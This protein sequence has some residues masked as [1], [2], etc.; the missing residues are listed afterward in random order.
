VYTFSS[1]EPVK[2]S[3]YNYQC[4]LFTRLCIRYVHV[5]GN[6]EQEQQPL[7]VRR[8]LG[9]GPSSP[10]SLD[11]IR[12]IFKHRALTLQKEFYVSY[13]KTNE[14][15]LFRDILCGI[16]NFWDRCCHPYSSCSSVMQRLDVLI[17]CVVLFGVVYLAWCDVA[18]DPTAS[19]QNWQKLQRRPWQWLDKHSGKKAWAAHGESELADTQ[20]D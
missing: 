12:T 2:I 16:H 18:I 1:V 20:K 11:L 9:S 4:S 19:V 14:L 13:T 10:W 5:S 6:S 15:R 17:F 8:S 7:H 3:T